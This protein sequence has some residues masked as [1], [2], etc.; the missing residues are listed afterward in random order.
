MKKYAKMKQ[1]VFLL[2]STIALKK[3]EIVEL[4]EPTNLPATSSQ[5]Y[6]CKLGSKDGVLV[7]PSEITW[8]RRAEA[9]KLGLQ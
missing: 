8:L 7:E 9:R 1:D 3:G 5:W 4:H 2:G 6:A